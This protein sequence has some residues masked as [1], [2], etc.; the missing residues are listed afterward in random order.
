MYEDSWSGVSGGL[1]ATAMASSAAR[2]SVAGA[3][4]EITSAPPA[5]RTARRE[6]IAVLSGHGALPQPII[7]AA[8]L[9]ARRMAI[10]VP[11][12]H[13]SPVKASRISASVG[14]FLSRRNAAAVMIQPL[15]Q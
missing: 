13:F 11:Q 4:I 1:A 7:A 3:P 8:R 2:A 14:F 12:R 10:W 15:M 6:K 5:L 9:T